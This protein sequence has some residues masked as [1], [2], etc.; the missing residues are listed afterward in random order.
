MAPVNFL[1]GSVPFAS[2]PDLPGIGVV[3]F[4]VVLAFLMLDGA[5]KALHK[6]KEQ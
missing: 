4:V 5:V 1:T 6:K 3:G 2:N